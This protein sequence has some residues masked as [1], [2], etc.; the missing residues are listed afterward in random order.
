MWHQ[1]KMT[2]LHVGNVMMPKNTVNMDSPKICLI[3]LAAK[4]LQG[5]LMLALLKVR[6]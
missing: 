2:Y 3:N 6:K 1:T 4:G 5:K